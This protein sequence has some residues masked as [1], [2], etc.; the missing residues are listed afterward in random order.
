MVLRLFLP[1]WSVDMGVSINGGTPKCMD[2]FM[3]NPKQKWMMTGGTTILGNLQLG[4][5]PITMGIITINNRD[6]MWFYG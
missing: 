6:I 3:E 1:P 5:A 2:D 4:I